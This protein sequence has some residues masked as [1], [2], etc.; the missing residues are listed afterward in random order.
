MPT[1]DPLLPVTLLTGF[2]GA[3]KT[4]LLN[5]MLNEGYGGER[6]A[7]F[8]N[9]F[10]K[11]S[12][13]A[14]LIQHKNDQLIEL[15]NGCV[16]CTL[17]VNLLGSIRKVIEQGNVDRVIIEASGISNTPQLIT[18]LDSDEI[19][20]RL[21]EVIAVVD[22]RR[23]VRHCERMIILQ[24]QVSDA[25]IVLINRCD[26]ASEQVIRETHQWFQAHQPDTCIV[27]T[28]HCD[29]NMNQLQRVAKR[30]ASRSNHGQTGPKDTTV[31][32][33]AE[34]RLPS[35]L[36]RNA[37]RVA[38]E[39]LPA[40]ILRLKGIV[41]LDDCLYSVQMVGP[42]ITLEQVDDTVVEKVGV[43]VLISDR[44]VGEEVIEAFADIPGAQVISGKAQH[45]H[46]ERKLSHSPVDTGVDPDAD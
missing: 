43:L 30:Y 22:A 16:C 32:H 34:V 5:R 24:A 37:L 23:F 33:T 9:D 11:I 29:V 2:L 41:R 31:W 39:R 35:D 1:T 36:T 27:E 40:D 38:A 45:G 15:S 7:V 21:D 44:P 12:V 46:P 8:V 26:Q 10:G 14:A 18:L 17:Q 25:D 3:G 4:T 28:N 6:V 19:P 42:S 20:V 13:D